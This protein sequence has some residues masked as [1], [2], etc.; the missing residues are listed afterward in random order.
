LSQ[1]KQIV[2]ALEILG[3]IGKACTAKICLRKALGLYQRTH[4]AI[5]HQNPLG[6]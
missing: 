4:A 2:I 3:M 5:E 6:K 1:I